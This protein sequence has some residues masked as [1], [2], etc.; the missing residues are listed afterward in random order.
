MMFEGEARR[1][2][3]D[4]LH[5]LDELYAVECELRRQAFLRDTEHLRFLKLRIMSRALPERVVFHP[6]KGFTSETV[7]PAETQAALDTIDTE[8]EAVAKAYELRR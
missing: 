6:D 8:I 4:R 2:L 1:M 7:Y 5:T 3:G